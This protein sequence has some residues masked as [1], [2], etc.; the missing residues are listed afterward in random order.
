MLLVRNSSGDLVTPDGSRRLRTHEQNAE[1]DELGCCIHNPSDNIQNRENWPYNWREDRG[2]MERLCK[3]G[4][5]H[6]D[7]DS[8]DYLERNGQRYQNDHGCDFCCMGGK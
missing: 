5:G 2:I 3:H 4:C 7:F 8:A 1:C 6:P